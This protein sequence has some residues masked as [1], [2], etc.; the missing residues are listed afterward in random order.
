MSFASL[1]HAQTSTPAPG[2]ASL[3]RARAAWDKGDFEISEPLFK[4][5]LDEGGL[6]PDE[7]I[8]AYA[9]LGAA[10][11]MM[12]KK[13]Q[14]LDAFRVA[15]TYDP[16]F[17][18]PADAGKVAAALGEQARKEKARLGAISLSMEAPAST[19]PGEGF[20]V[21]AALD[22]PHVPVV[23]RVAV[24]VLDPLSKKTYAKTE[25]SAAQVK[26]EIPSSV[27]LPGA[28]LLVRV[29]ALD[30]KENRLATSEQRVKVEQ[31]DKPEP[32]IVS[33]P[34]KK[35]TATKPAEKKSSGGFWSTAWPWVLGGMAIA[36]GGAAVYFGTQRYDDVTVGAARIEGVR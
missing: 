22:T 5:A 31:V 28:S 7:V 3:A 17:V 30:P 32:V 15:A 18:V 19:K 6:A 9:H 16:K 13:A 36:G 27:G 4:Q 24:F 10:R 29:D 23:Y 20:R 34:E 35:D 21:S 14:A 25:N 26:F 33:R 8:E 1:S 2:A 11:A 12:N